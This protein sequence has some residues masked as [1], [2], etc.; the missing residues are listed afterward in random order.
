MGSPKADLLYLTKVFGGVYH[1][2][3]VVSGQMMLFTMGGHV[4]NPIIHHPQ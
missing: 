4:V 1:H 3:M 2:F